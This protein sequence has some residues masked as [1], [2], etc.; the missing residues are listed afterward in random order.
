MESM[1]ISGIAKSSESKQSLDSINKSAVCAK[2]ELEA[3][4]TLRI[5]TRF[6]ADLH[7]E[8]RCSECKGIFPLESHRFHAWEP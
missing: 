3:V 6:M 8:Y 4:R 2:F 5:Y 7:F 1:L